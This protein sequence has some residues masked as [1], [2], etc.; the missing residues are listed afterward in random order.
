LK[1]EVPEFGKE[2]IK[3]EEY[4]WMLIIV[5]SRVYGLS[6]DL[7]G[8]TKGLVPFADMINHSSQSDD[9]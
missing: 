6:I 5:S 2:G 9:N 3:F 8:N 4:K 1:E 7:I